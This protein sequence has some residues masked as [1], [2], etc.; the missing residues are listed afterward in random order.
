[1][2]KNQWKRVFQTIFAVMVCCHFLGAPCMGQSTSDRIVNTTKTEQQFRIVCIDSPT[3]L[4]CTIVLSEPKKVKSEG[5]I[6][7]YHRVDIG[8]DDDPPPVMGDYSYSSMR[9]IVARARSSEYISADFVYKR[10]TQAVL[11]IV[12]NGIDKPYGGEWLALNSLETPIIKYVSSGDPLPKE[13]K[14]LVMS[15]SGSQISLNDQIRKWTFQ[16]QRRTCIKHFKN[17]VLQDKLTTYTDW[18]LFSE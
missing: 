17:G 3:D 10:S 18:K 5:V 11:M 15:A 12:K 13:G 2:I 14:S 8:S 4:N 6:E 1:M 7:H 16:M 9:T